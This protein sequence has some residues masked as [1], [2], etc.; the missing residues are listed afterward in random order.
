[1]I[2]GHD[3]SKYSL[4]PTALFDKSPVL[5]KSNVSATIIILSSN[6]F[7]LECAQINY[8]SLHCDAH[9]MNCVLDTLCAIAWHWRSC[10]TGNQNLT[11]EKCRLHAID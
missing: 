3:D 8:M 11:K 5:I 6:F 2:T 4:K 7:M 10:Q 9:N 1:M